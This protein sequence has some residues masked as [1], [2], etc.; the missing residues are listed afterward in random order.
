MKNAI[1]PSVTTHYDFGN[2]NYDLQ[3]F[4]DINPQNSFGFCMDTIPSLDNYNHTRLEDYSFPF[5]PSSLLTYPQQAFPS[6]ILS[7]DVIDNSSDHHQQSNIFLGKKILAPQFEVDFHTIERRRKRPTEDNA[8]HFPRSSRWEL[9]SDKRNKRNKV[10]RNDQEAMQEHK[11]GMPTKRSQK[12]SD[13][14]TALQKLVS[15]YGKTDTASVLQEA[16]LYIKLIQE[17]IQNLYRM[18]SSPCESIRVSQSQGSGKRWLDL[19]SRELCLVPVSFTKA[20]ALD[21]PIDKCSTY[22]H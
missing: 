2:F 8:I 4:S 1:L 10:T 6:N 13:K 14:I 3:M 5:Q 9:H 21:D 16:S 22:K 19:R 7:C 11:L 18:M 20:V 12:L 15:P 17:Q